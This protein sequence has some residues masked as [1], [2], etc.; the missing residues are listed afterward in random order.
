[1]HLLHIDIVKEEEVHAENNMG[2]NLKQFAMEDR[3][4]EGNADDAHTRKIRKNYDK[5]TDK[6]D[7]E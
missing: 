6:T 5:N 7:E 3:I 1:M 2:V 4:P